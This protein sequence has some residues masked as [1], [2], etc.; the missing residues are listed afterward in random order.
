VPRA[1]GDLV[2]MAMA[3]IVLCVGD[4]LMA[5]RQEVELWRRHG[6]D[7]FLTR[8]TKWGIYTE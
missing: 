2:A 7:K 6:A 3:R 1:S 4:G 8:L 5:A